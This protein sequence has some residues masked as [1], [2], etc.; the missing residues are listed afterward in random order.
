LA[1]LRGSGP[2]GMAGMRGRRPLGS[3]PSLARPFIGI[4]SER[5]REYCHARALPYAVDPT[6]ADL[7]LRRNA[8]RAALAQLRPI[9]PGLDRAVARAAELLAAERDATKRSELRRTVREQL[10]ADENLRDIDFTHIEAAVR[11]LEEGRTG[12]FHMKPGVALRIKR[13]AICGIKRV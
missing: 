5:L 13:G 12:T 11:A 4:A 3:G 8:V 10:A 1:L 7:G 6:N 2:T 9:F